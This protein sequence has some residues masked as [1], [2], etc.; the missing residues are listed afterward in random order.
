M[1]KGAGGVYV[2]IPFCVRKCPY[3][4]FYSAPA[5][6]AERRAYTEAVLRAVETAP[7]EFAADTLYIGGGTPSLLPPEDLIAVRAAVGRRFGLKNAECTVEANP[8]AVTAESL[9]RLADGGF[10]RISFGVQAL[11]DTLLRT[12]GR[13]HTARDALDAVEA[14]ARAGFRHISADLMLAVP[15]QTIAHIRDAIRLLS[16]TPVDHL[17]AYLL[18][19]EEGTPFYGRVAEPEEG[20]A[21]DCYRAA[22][23]ACAQCGFS[24]YE[25]SNFARSAKAQS[26][27]NLHYWHCDESLGI[28]PAAHS[29]LAGKRFFFPRDTGAFSAAADPWRL[30]VPDGDGGGEEERILL[31]LRLCEGIAPA[32]FSP[33]TAKLLSERAAPLIAAGLMKRRGDRLAL[34]R[35]GFLVSNAVIASLI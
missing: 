33:D 26:R 1:S 25:I 13:I 31:G 19:I 17:S 30:P 4:D 12:L 15:G 8:G 10:T 28:G 34:T 16:A 32:A 20:F 21:A 22:A 3:C 27:H 5:G 2:H 24:Q 9:K 35:E 14:A 23:D 18:Q 7:W 11:D 29:F 6:E